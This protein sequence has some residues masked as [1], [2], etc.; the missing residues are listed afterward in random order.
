MRGQLYDVCQ[1]QCYFDQMDK[2]AAV[3]LL[4]LLFFGD[5]SA[6]MQKLLFLIVPSLCPFNQ[7]GLLSSLWRRESAGPCL[8]TLPRGLF[9]LKR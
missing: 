7:I 2:F 6:T 4:W 1:V 8:L 5:L 9:V 3:L